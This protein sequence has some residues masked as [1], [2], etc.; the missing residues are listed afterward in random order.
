MVLRTQALILVLLA[1]A[2]C[3]SGWSDA[4]EL[5]Y[6]SGGAVAFLPELYRAGSIFF[7]I[8]YECLF[9]ALRVDAEE[10]R[11]EYWRSNFFSVP[12]DRYQ[13]TES[14]LAELTE[15]Q[16][17]ERRDG[18]ESA[19]LPSPLV[20]GRSEDWFVGYHAGVDAIQRGL[21]RYE[22]YRVNGSAV[23]LEAGPPLFDPR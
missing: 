3:R 22:G 19:F 10:S 1:L 7:G 6:S 8:H 2:S 23:S 13:H 21:L 12:D 15:A 11:T 17:S 20:T 4:Q 18:F 16:I 5:N 14:A 9:F